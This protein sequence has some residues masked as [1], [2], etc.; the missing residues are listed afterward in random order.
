MVFGVASGNFHDLKE[1]HLSEKIETEAE[2]KDISV[3]SRRRWTC[4][5][6]CQRLS[7]TNYYICKRCSRSWDQRQLKTDLLS[8]V[9]TKGLLAIPSEVKNLQMPSGAEKLKASSESEKLQMPS[10]FEGLLKSIGNFKL[11]ERFKNLRGSDSWLSKLT[12]SK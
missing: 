9:E 6:G 1:E 3:D 7:G 11:M 4:K 5:R 2:L 10:D 8:S 12:K